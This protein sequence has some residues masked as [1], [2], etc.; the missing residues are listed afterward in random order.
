MET[1]KNARPEM[2]R[3]EFLGKITRTASLGIIAG[4]SAVLVAR[5]AGARTLW[6]I[7][8]EKCAHCTN[9]STQCVLAESAVKCMHRF[10]TC[11]YC[12]PCFG[13]FD[14][15]GSADGTGAENQTCPNGA[16]RRRFIEDPY[17]EYSVDDGLCVGCG[18]CVKGCR[19]F[20]N[21]SLMLQVS[22][23]LCQHCN[24]C[25]IAVSCPADAFVRVT[26]DNPYPALKGMK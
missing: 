6:Q 1:E 10:D 7:D 21:G 26:P 4:A 13:Y 19:D 18:K 12:K 15:S 9:C 22:Q 2:K 17:Y 11:G 3:R 16:L 25:S 14:L 24:V 23:D 20:G 8:P 5:S